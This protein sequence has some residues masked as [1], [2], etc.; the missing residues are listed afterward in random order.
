V[1]R[2]VWCRVFQDE[3][4]LPFDDDRFDAFED[5]GKLGGTD[6]G[7]AF[8]VAGEGNGKSE[9]SGFEPLVPKS[10]SVPVPV[11]SAIL[12]LDK[13]SRSSLMVHSDNGLNLVVCQV[14]YAGEQSFVVMNCSK[15]KERNN[16]FKKNI[17]V[18]RK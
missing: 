4:F 5:H 2:L 1:S 6:E 10:V 15:R 7:D 3:T 9:A 12:E 18:C 16:R 11:K 17:C 13:S 14:D 8:A